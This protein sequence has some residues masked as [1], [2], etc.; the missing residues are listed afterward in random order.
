M[1]ENFW[2]FFKRIKFIIK[3]P[4]KKK[5]YNARFPPVWNCSSWSIFSNKTNLKYKNFNIFNCLSVFK[6]LYCSSNS[7]LTCRSKLVQTWARIQ[8]KWWIFVIAPSTTRPENCLVRLLR[9][10]SHHI[11]CMCVCVMII[12]HTSRKYN[13]LNEMQKFRR[14]YYWGRHYLNKYV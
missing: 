12:W 10:L 7:E 4:I 11:K 14:R 3:M 13:I 5:K 6:K 2:I 9:D 1:S 8:K